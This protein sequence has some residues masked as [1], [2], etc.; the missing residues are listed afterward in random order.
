MGLLSVSG[1]VTAEAVDVDD[2]TARG[3]TV[4]PCHRIKTRIQRALHTRTEADVLH[5]PTLL[6]DEVM[7]VLGEILGELI[8]RVV[9]TMNESAHHTCFLEH[10]QIAI[11]RALRKC[12]RTVEQ[13]RECHRAVDSCKCLDDVTTP[14]GVALVPRA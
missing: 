8:V 10:S 5:A 9:R 3:K 6:A 4:L 13:H 11:R 7:V 2:V 14:V 1:A 12:R